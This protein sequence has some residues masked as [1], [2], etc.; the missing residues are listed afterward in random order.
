MPEGNSGSNGSSKR[1]TQVERTASLG[2][3]RYS[4]KELGLIFKRAAEMQEE[5]GATQ[6]SGARSDSGFTLAEMQ[7]IAS[8]VG[9]A[10]RHVATAAAGLRS[11]GASQQHFL[12]GAPTRFRFE[13]TLDVEVSDDV[14]GE[15]IDVARRETGMQGQVQQVLGAVRWNS[16][17]GS[18]GW[19]ALAMTRRKGRTTICV[20]SA[21]TDAAALYSVFGMVGGLLGTI[22][23]GAT[24]SATAG[25][26]VPAAALGGIVFGGGGAW[27]TVRSSWRRFA[28]RATERTNAL[29]EKLAELTEQAINDQH[30]RDLT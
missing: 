26:A 27:L 11:G 13:H 10:S 22:L 15:M 25:V 20:L 9:I 7:Q 19:N 3:R 14:I 29:G 30:T 5:V 6:E 2:E 4:E 12:L 8:D 18:L 21:R 23:V 28:Q 17:C 16:H 24:L 1:S